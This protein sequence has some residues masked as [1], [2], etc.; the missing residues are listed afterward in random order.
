MEHGALS[1]IDNIILCGE[2]NSDE[3]VSIISEAYPRAKVSKQGLESVEVENIDSFSTES[4]FIIPTAVAEEYFAEVEKKLSGINLLPNYIKEEQKLF[5]LGWQGYLAV[6]LIM[7]SASFFVYKTISNFEELK[8]KDAEISKI[9]LIQAQNQATVSKIKSYENKVQNVDQTKAILDQLSSGTGILSDQLKKL[10]NFTNFRR[11]IWMSSL[12]MDINK[13]V[14]LGGYTF[15]R[16]MVKELSDSYNGS[17]LQNIIY[18]PLRDTRSFKFT[19]D[20]G[21]LLG[22]TTNEKEK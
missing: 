1:N 18:E 2:D 20:A 14:K 15:V 16:P 6:L 10:S 4:S 17:I 12:N 13:N 11:N 21:N 7:L 5:H 9:Q 3:L 22:G 19:I 8:A